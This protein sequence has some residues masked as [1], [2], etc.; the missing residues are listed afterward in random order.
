M[1]RNRKNQSVAV[2]LGPGVKAL[3]ICLLIAASG[4]GYVWQKDQL[5]DLSRR[6]VELEKR[7]WRLRVRNAQA[8][9]QLMQLQSAPSLE[10]R[11]KELGLGLAQPAA[12]QIVRLAE[13]PLTR[14]VSPSARDEPQYAKQERLPERQRRP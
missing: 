12:T 1:A 5:N 6:K 8:H 13:A 2:R 10:A 7:L 4:V 11:V 3:V 14:T 9:G